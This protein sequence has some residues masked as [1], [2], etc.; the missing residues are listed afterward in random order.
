[1]VE[2]L[3]RDPELRS[4]SAQLRISPAGVVEILST[5]D[6]ILGGPQNQIYLGCR[7]PAHPDYRLTI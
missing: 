7:F 6:Q 2:T 1:M 3:L 5:H 4:P